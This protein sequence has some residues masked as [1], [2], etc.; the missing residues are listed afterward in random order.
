MTETPLTGVAPAFLRPHS[1]TSSVRLSNVRGKKRQFYWS[2]SLPSYLNEA[3][4]FARYV[5]TFPSLI[6]RIQLFDLRNPKIP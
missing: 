6:L 1:V 5:S 4:T 2:Q 3:F